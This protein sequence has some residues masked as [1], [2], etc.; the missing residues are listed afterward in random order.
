MTHKELKH[1]SR[2]N[3]D[4]NP[5]ATTALVTHSCYYF[6]Y[7]DVHSHLPCI[8][9]LNVCSYFLFCHFQTNSLSLCLWVQTPQE[10]ELTWFNQYRPV[11]WEECSWQALSYEIDKATDDCPWV[12][13]QALAN[14]EGRGGLHGTK[15]GQHCLRCCLL[16]LASAKELKVCTSD[17]HCHNSIV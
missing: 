2:H 6:S 4:S 9:T 5:T 10:K 16:P 3:H 14:F 15:P 8:P 13:N 7:L 12:K 1:H 17:M 11:F